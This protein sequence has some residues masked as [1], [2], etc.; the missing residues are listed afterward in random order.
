MGQSTTLGQLIKDRF[1]GTL[2][3]TSVGDMSIIITNDPDY[4]A[5]TWT[6]TAT[7]APKS[8]P[9]MLFGN[10]ALSLTDISVSLTFNGPKKAATGVIR[11][12][13]DFGGIDFD[14]DIALSRQV[15]TFSLTSQLGAPV[16][17][18]SVVKKLGARTAPSDMKTTLID[19]IAMSIAY[20]GKA[21]WTL[22]S[23]ARL[24]QTEFLPFASGTTDAAL[25]LEYRGQK[26]L[27]RTTFEL[28]VQTRIG[29]TGHL[30]LSYDF[31]AKPTAATS[32]LKGSLQ[33]D[34]G[35][36][37]VFEDMLRAVGLK[38]QTKGA[39]TVSAPKGLDIAAGQVVLDFA[40]HT[41][42][43]SGQNSLKEDAFVY[44]ERDAESRNLAL[45]VATEKG[46]KMA[47]LSP[48]FAVV[49]E[50]LT[51]RQSFL[52]VA[53]GHVSIAN[54]IFPKLGKHAFTLEKGLNVGLDLAMDRSQT[55]LLGKAVSGLLGGT[56]ELLLQATLGP[57]AKDT[58]FSATLG[59]LDLSLD[60]PG[61]RKP[62]TMEIRNARLILSLQPSFEVVG[63]VLFPAPQGQHVEVSGA[64]R[65][66]E[67]TAGPVL[68][69]SGNAKDPSTSLTPP[70]NASGVK[71][72]EIGA[73]FSVEPEAFVMGLHGAMWIGKENASFGFAF[74]L[75]ELAPTFV[76][77]TYSH[78]DLAPMFKALC[79]EA[80]LP[81]ELRSGISFRNLEIWSCTD[82][83][84]TCRISKDV[85]YRDGF[86][87]TGDA[88]VFRFPAHADLKVTTAG[89][90]GSLQMG[91]ALSVPGIFTIADA[92]DQAKGPQFAFDTDR[93]PHLL[94][95]YYVN[96][97]GVSD[98]TTLTLTNSGFWLKTKIDFK[99][100]SITLKCGLG[101]DSRGRFTA[102]ISA[103]ADFGKKPIKLTGKLKL[104]TLDI[105]MSSKTGVFTVGAT[106]HYG[107]L[108]KS[109]TVTISLKDIAHK[110]V[111]LGKE[112]EKELQKM[113][114]WF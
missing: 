98:T 101:A 49:D 8:Y 86:R 50:V 39:T 71:L 13:L 30:A 16:S 72:T 99:G 4:D 5:K 35:A 96:V 17:L 2:V 112:I 66:E 59:N 57:S 14:V 103:H 114:N 90:S 47:D 26:K 94:A 15:E 40:N 52:A 97:L 25:M 42:L 107:L 64:V 48:E 33:T 37:I 85:C 36:P 18:A 56:P 92:K 27:K 22:S 100:E 108:P 106:A 77:A 73:S 82:P 21:G 43:V 70:K 79:H 83:S 1:G 104:S 111:H 69:F 54:E 88:T 45:G 9:Y 10:E 3:A 74:A 102:A 60:V 109:T 75:P 34:A 67:T 68:S 44:L 38:A 53:T 84:G 80:K 95:D 28:A 110:L 29:Q 58:E 89:M 46:W 12:D 20:D 81:K 41:L 105:S 11:A 113:R 63:D 76:S 78:L 55:S 93:S 65:V 24:S 51:F 7:G 19:L 61:A 62:A 31:A 87:F 91:K 6:V 32:V 23:K